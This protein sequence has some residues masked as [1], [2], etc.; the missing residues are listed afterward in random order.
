MLTRTLVYFAIINLTPPFSYFIHLPSTM[1]S[2]FYFYFVRSMFPFLLNQSQSKAGVANQMI[3]LCFPRSSVI[4]Q[5]NVQ[6]ATAEKKKLYIR[7]FKK[8]SNISG[9]DGEYPVAQTKAKF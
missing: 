2:N 3:C 9:F 8:I 7:H 5:L 4:G 1:L 6:T